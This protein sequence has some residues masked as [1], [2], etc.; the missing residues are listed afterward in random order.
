MK[1]L[2]LLGAAALV[3]VAAA[4]PA[5]AQEVIYNPGYCAQFYLDANCQNKGPNN[6]YTGDYQRRF[7]M[8]NTVVLG[9]SPCAM[10]VDSYIIRGS[11][12]VYCY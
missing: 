11:R 12:R 3:C 2:A 6:P 1:K 8:R 9:A 4:T 5:K 7:E 10:G